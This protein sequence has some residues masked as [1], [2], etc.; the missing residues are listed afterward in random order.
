MTTQLTR[1][2][3]QA[4]IAANPAIVLVEA[5][6]A[7]YFRD[8]HLPGAL[9]LPHDQVRELAPGLLPNKDAEIVTYCASVACQN[10]HIAAKLLTQMGYTNVAVYAGGKQ[11]WIETGLPVESELATAP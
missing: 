10:S 7:K 2:D 9:H 3:L 8:R 11:D 5:L 6:P 1:T 4:R